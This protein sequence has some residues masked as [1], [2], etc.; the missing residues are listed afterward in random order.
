MKRGKGYQG[1]S[2][3]DYLAEEPL[4]RPN[5]GSARQAR[6]TLVAQTPRS[7]GRS[8]PTNNQLL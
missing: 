1:D 7:A 4:G 2:D 6:R 8:R 5:G 3:D